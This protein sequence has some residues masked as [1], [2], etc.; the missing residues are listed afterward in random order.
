M[1][2]A[3][4]P[5][6]RALSIYQENPVAMLFKRFYRVSALRDAGSHVISRQKYLESP[7]VQMG[8]RA[9][10]RKDVPSRD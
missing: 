10:G 9:G 8:G 3:V 1:T 4:F 2:N 6:Q 5:T 7:V